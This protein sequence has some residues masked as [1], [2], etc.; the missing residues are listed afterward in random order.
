MRPDAAPTMT[1]EAE[2]SLRSAEREGNQTV[3]IMA[4]CITFA[5]YCDKLSVTERCVQM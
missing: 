3:E 2:R 4:D 1:E 5:N